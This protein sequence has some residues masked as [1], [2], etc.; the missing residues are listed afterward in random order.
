MHGAL[1]SAHPLI[2]LRPP[3]IMLTWPVGVTQAANSQPCMFTGFRAIDW[4]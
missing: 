4:F 1:G 3:L 2:R